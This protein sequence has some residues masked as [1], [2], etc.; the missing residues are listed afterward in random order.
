MYYRNIELHF[1]DSNDKVYFLLIPAL[2]GFSPNKSVTDWSP[3]TSL[4]RDLHA[5]QGATVRWDRLWGQNSVWYSPLPQYRQPTAPGIIRIGAD[6]TIPEVFRYR[7]T[8]QITLSRSDSGS[9]RLTS[10]WTFQP[11]LCPCPSGTRRMTKIRDHL[12]N[13]RNLLLVS[14]QRFLLSKR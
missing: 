5:S 2:N 11:R 7:W 12:L 14:L 6:V 3:I 9:S 1:K 4:F 8:L 10:P 13:K